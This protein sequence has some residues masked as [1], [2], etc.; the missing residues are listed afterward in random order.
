[1][2]KDLSKIS[3]QGL[4]WFIEAMRETKEERYLEEQEVDLV[5]KVMDEMSKRG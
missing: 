2:K 5:F 4:K 3:E 1:M